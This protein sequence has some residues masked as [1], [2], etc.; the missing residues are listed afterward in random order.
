M[1][2]E[3]GNID[4]VGITVIFLLKYAVILATTHVTYTYTYTYTG[5]ADFPYQ[6]YGLYQAGRF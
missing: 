1:V 2:R 5:T 4:I 6:R 3:H